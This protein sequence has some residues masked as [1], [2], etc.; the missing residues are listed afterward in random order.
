MNAKNLLDLVKQYGAAAHEA[1]KKGDH[2]KAD[3][4]QK[5]A[6]EN[7]LKLYQLLGLS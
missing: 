3:A 1:A 2:G 5:L 4:M 7:L 6:E